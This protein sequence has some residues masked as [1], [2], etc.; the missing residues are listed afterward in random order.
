MRTHHLALLLLLIICTVVISYSST[1]IMRH[2]NYDEVEEARVPILP[3]FKLIFERLLIDEEGIIR[4]STLV[5][6]LLK[7]LPIPTVLKTRLDALVNYVSLFNETCSSIEHQ[8]NLMQGLIKEGNLSQARKLRSDIDSLFDNATVTLIKVRIILND[9]QRTYPIVKSVVEPRINYLEERLD[10]LRNRYNKVLHEI[11]ILSQEY[12]V[13]INT[14]IN[15]T[16]FP[17]KAYPGDN[18]S[19]YGFLFTENGEPLSSRLTVE[20][21]GFFKV[22]TRT[23]KHGYFRLTFRA[24]S[25]P[26][27]YYVIVKYVPENLTYKAS[28]A[29]MKLRVM[30][31]KTSIKI[32]NYTKA[33]Y[34]QERIIIEGVIESNSPKVK[35]FI[36]LTMDGIT[37][38]VTIRTSSFK[39]YLT[40]PYYIKE[41]LHELK[42]SFIPKVP[43]LEPSQ[44]NVTILVMNPPHGLKLKVTHPALLISTNS[45]TVHVTPTSELE[46]KLMIIVK[47]VTM[48]GRTISSRAVIIKANQEHH[49]TLTYSPNIISNYYRIE[50]LAIPQNPLIKYTRYIGTLYI[51]NFQSLLMTLLTL[52]AIVLL[53]TRALATRVT[54]KPP[55][56]A[57]TIRELAKM[58]AMLEEV[59]KLP[60]ELHEPRTL[61]KTLNLLEA[62]L[63]R[64]LN[65]RFSLSMTHR[66]FSEEVKKKNPLIGSLLTSMVLIFERAYY[67]LKKLKVLEIL[68]LRSAYEKILKLLKVRE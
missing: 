66:E 16:L 51:I 63:A 43:F 58:E 24:P 4:N 31:F 23:N 35:G 3:L 2:M 62:F 8:L 64:V 12:Q 22:I 1:D 47:L 50:V 40:L 28:Y 48:R 21:R 32:V 61:R 7:E 17:S 15:A 55:E 59:E 18:V 53:A 39:A 26:D 49:L 29:L 5:L 10:K 27:E 56:K 36:I 44:S 33:L 6:S 65:I 42:V 13:R 34:P 68:F 20:L 46:S 57:V 30:P 60:E 41:G 67:G 37:S 25:I 52:L 19:V 45:I 54:R 14:L 11:E 9:I 38:E